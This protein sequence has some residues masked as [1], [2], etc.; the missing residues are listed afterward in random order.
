MVDFTTWTPQSEL[1][2]LAMGADPVQMREGEAV[3]TFS[4]YP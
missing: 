1:T 4:R 2:D 3:C